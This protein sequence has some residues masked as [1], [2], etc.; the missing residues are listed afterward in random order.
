MGCVFRPLNTSQ[1]AALINGSPAFLNFERLAHGGA[2]AERATPEPHA[3]ERT[4]SRR[5]GATRAAPPPSDVA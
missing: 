4:P 2:V 5:T 1:E 3:V